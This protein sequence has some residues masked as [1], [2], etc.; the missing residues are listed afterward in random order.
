[1]GIAVII[2]NA[3][4]QDAN[5]GKVTLQQ[6]VPLRSITIVGP[7]EITEPT[8]FTVNFFPA[9]TSQR[10][11]VWSI[12]SG[13]TYASINAETGE[14]T[15]I[16]GAAMNGVVIRA[17]SSADNNIYAEKTVTVSYGMV[18]EEKLALVG[19]GVATLLTNYY[20]KKNTRVVYDF[21]VNEYPTLS[22]TVQYR[23]IWGAY[24]GD[25]APMTRHQLQMRS[26]PPSGFTFQ[27]A[28]FGASDSS[29]DGTK[30]YDNK[31][32]PPVGARIKNV[33]DRNGIV[34]SYNQ[35]DFVTVSDDTFTAPSAPISIFSLNTTSANVLKMSLYGFECYEGDV[36]KLKLV[37]C[38]LLEN[39]SGTLAG[40]GQSHLA[41]ENGMWDKVGNKFYGNVRNSGSFSVID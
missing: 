35:S 11:I 34:T 4:F 32:V 13:G 14:L 24:S 23:A 28:N 16:V 33:F 2:P 1:M 31:A 10:G 27:V 8:P 12:V 6:G 21:K 41:G 39:I 26:S 29:G 38:T 36:L 37:P 5:L 19:D 17:T 30:S 25:S 7:D 22:S 18:Y 15:P 20:V 9:N 3:N 40:D